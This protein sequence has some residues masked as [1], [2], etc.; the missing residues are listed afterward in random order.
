MVASDI[1]V[2]DLGITVMHSPRSSIPPISESYTNVRCY[3]KKREHGAPYYTLTTSWRLD[4]AENEPR[5][6]LT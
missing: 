6:Q 2:A 3:V 1:R 4:S 5:R